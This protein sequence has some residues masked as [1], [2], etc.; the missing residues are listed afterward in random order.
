MSM[1]LRIVAQMKGNFVAQVSNYQYAPSVIASSG[2]TL[3][4]IQMQI[5]LI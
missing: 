2:I 1:I 3:N 5:P 4:I